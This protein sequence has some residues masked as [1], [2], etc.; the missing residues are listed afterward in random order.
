ML[1]RT[2]PVVPPM[3]LNSGTYRAEGGT[4][5]SGTKGNPPVPPPS[6]REAGV[7]R[8]RT[9]SSGRRLAHPC[10]P[11]PDI[12]ANYRGQSHLGGNRTQY[13]GSVSSRAGAGIRGL[14]D[15]LRAASCRAASGPPQGLLVPAVTCGG[16][17]RAGRSAARY[18]GLLCVL[19]TSH[20]SGFSCWPAVM[21]CLQRPT[22]PARAA[23]VPPQPRAGRSPPGRAG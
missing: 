18:A 11:R 4:N 16:A 1:R 17:K 23:A 21:V 14:P 12:P 5:V 15:D 20:P 8:Y 19:R 22:F 9:P 10:F 13:P 7:R 6:R 3:I 2:R